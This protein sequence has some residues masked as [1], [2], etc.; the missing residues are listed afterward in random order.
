MW[1]GSWLYLCFFLFLAL[2]PRLWVH[3]QTCRLGVAHYHSSLVCFSS[4]HWVPGH[5]EGSL[6][7]HP[8]IPHPSVSSVP[9]S[10]PPRLTH[11]G[12]QVTCETSRCRI[13]C[14]KCVPSLQSHLKR[15]ILQAC[16]H[17]LQ[18]LVAFGWVLVWSG[19]QAEPS[20]WHKHPLGP[21]RM[22]GVGSAPGVLR[23]L[24]YRSVLPHRICGFVSAW[25]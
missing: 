15:S 24:P 7:P 20:P 14:V 21:A 12:P 16:Q 2:F 4:Q 8:C 25:F 9:I 18:L 10:S 19:G 23:P 6:S 13:V 22:G 11:T 5:S 17:P 3:L 1:K